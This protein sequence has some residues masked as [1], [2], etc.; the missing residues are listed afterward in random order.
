MPGSLG[1]WSVLRTI[2]TGGSC[3][4]KLGNDPQT[5]TKVAIK[6]MND[7]LGQQA[8]DLLQTEIEKMKLLQHENII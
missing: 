2:G 6:I 1:K 7:D 8:K 3:K 5:N 4:V